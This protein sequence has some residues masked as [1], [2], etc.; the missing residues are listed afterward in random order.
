MQNYDSVRSIAISLKSLVSY[1]VIE[2]A[3]YPFS[4]QPHYAT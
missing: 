3:F 4:R 2:E 1:E